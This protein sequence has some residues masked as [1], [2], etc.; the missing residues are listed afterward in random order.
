[1]KSCRHKEEGSRACFKWP[2]EQL[3]PY[4]P[5]QF[6]LSYIMPSS[7]PG[8]PQFYLLSVQPKTEQFVQTEAKM[9]AGTYARDICLYRPQKIKSR[10][11]TDLKGSRN[12]LR[13]NNC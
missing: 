1:M 13:E 4:V 10:E 2:G 7:S 9:N 6:I 5:S 12:Y 11:V 3:T 8:T